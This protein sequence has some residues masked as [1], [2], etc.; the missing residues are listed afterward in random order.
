M[1]LEQTMECKY[2]ERLGIIYSY[3]QINLKQQFLVA[4]PTTYLLCRLR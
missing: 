2:L 3:F 4:S 1:L